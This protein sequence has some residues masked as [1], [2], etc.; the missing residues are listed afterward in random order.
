[1]SAGWELTLTEPPL[2]TCVV[3]YFDLLGYGTMLQAASCQLTH[4]VAALAV[5]RIRDFHGSAQVDSL[6]NG[7]R[8]RKLNDAIVATRDL[9]RATP[10]PF[11]AKFDELNPISLSP[12]GAKEYWEF[13][14]WARD[15]HDRIRRDQRR[16]GYPGARTVACIGER[17][18]D[19][20]GDNLTLNMAFATAYLAEGQ[21]TKAG[22]FGDFFYVQWLSYPLPCRLPGGS[23]LA[24]QT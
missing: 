8:I 17:L 7:V 9:D 1:M 2:N 15:L 18:A 6:P 23:R 12:R 11:V 19:P 22:L 20:D 10:V 4:P 14:E 24:L 3:A 16:S 5:K 21:G 13:L